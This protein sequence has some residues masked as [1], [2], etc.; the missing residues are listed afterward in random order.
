MTRPRAKSTRPV[1]GSANAMPHAAL[2]RCSAS[3]Y[4]RG[5]GEAFPQAVAG[6]PVAAGGGRLRC[7]GRD[8]PPRPSPSMLPPASAAGCSKSLGPADPHPPHRLRNLRL[9]F[10]D[11]DEAERR[12]I[13]PPAVGKRG[14][15]FFEFFIMDRILADPGRVE[16]P[17]PGRGGGNLGRRPPADLRQRSFR[18]LRDHGLV[19]A[20][21]GRGSGAGL[22]RPQQPLHRCAHAPDPAAVWGQAAESPEGRATAGA[23]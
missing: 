18:Q 20:A 7:P 17:K 10:P 9:V 8:Y 12:R 21:A 14:R 4:L 3:P 19:R 13:A 6:F 23:G 5:N 1:T 2:R 11:W 15:V 16:F 22:S